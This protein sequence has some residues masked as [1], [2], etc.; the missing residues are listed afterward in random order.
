M[1]IL[2]FNL[3]VALRCAIFIWL[4]I[5]I[6]LFTNLLLPESGITTQHFYSVG[7][8]T[9]FLAILMTYLKY[10]QRILARFI[11]IKGVLSVIAAALILVWFVILITWFNGMDGFQDIESFMSFELVMVVLAFPSSIIGMILRFTVFQILEIDTSSISELRQQLI[12][13]W[14]MY[15]LPFLI[16]LYLTG[17]YLKI[18]VI[19]KLKELKI[20]AK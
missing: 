18:K 13:L 6:G 9:L 1:S 16:Q 14:L 8:A 17:K 19:H 11:A 3:G 7:A 10:D 2:I 20:N 4:Y 5:I 12:I 15:F